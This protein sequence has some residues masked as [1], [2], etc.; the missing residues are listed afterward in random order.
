[1]RQR[2]LNASMEEKKT[3][4]VL[5][6]FLYFGI[7]D[8]EKFCICMV[9]DQSLRSAL[10]MRR[11]VQKIATTTTHCAV[12]NSLDYCMFLA[13]S[14]FIIV[15]RWSGMIHAFFYYSFHSKLLLLVVAYLTLPF[16]FHSLNIPYSHISLSRVW[17]FLFI[18]YR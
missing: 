10:K 4:F 8:V 17:F 13:F 2:K 6:E 16:F 15:C 9:I 11:I 18:P 7:S 14:Y 3:F 5:C 1:M 12:Q